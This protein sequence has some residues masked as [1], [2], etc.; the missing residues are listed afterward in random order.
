PGAQRAHGMAVWGAGGTAGALLG[1][2]LGGWA[3]TRL[4]WPY[5][6]AP[7]VVMGLV[8]LPMIRR[9]GAP[10]APRT[11]AIDWWGVVT[12]G[13]G[14]LAL[15]GFLNIGDNV[16]W[17]RTPSVMLLPVVSLASFVA[18]ARHARRVE[19]P[20]VDL[21]PLANVDLATTA[22]L[23]FGIGAFSTAFFQT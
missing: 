18:F 16:D 12:F 4:G 8:A 3:C 20:I 21:R 22:F 23:C 7:A 1:A 14:I 2:L 6:F 13:L 11:V 15:S 10:T 5:I 19:Q 17:Y 9:E